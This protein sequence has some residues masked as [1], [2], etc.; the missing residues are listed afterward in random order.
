MAVAALSPSSL[1]KPRAERVV[2]ALDVGTSKVA[3]LIAMADGENPPRV[4]GAGVRACNGLRR[5]LVADMERT[6][7][8]I[9]SANTT[10]LAARQT[11][12]IHNIHT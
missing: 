7:T 3:A 6:E 2:A 12:T 5:G 4:I 10:I 1:L 8:A 9:R 11:H